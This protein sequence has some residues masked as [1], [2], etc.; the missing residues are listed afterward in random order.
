ME[1]G[2]FSTLY[3]GIALLVILAMVVSPR[4]DKDLQNEDSVLADVEI[5]EA[6]GQRKQA[7]KLLKDALAAK[8]KS[9][10]YKESR[11]V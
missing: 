6:Y 11:A 8:P 3:A 5:Y 9:W 2:S 7:R 10:V 1:M 4:K